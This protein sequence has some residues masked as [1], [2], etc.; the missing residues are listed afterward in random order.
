MMGPAT[1]SGVHANNKLDPLT[2]WLWKQ[3]I[4]NY[5]LHILFFS[6]RVVPLCEYNSGERIGEL[7]EPQIQS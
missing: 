1:V 5:I 4:G 6:L 3:T 2:R 7:P